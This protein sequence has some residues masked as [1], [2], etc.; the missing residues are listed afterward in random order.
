MDSPYRPRS[1]EMHRSRSRPRSYSPPARS[2][3]SARSRSPSSPRPSSRAPPPR[4]PP[5]VRSVRHNGD[6]KR[7]SRD[8]ARP[9]DNVSPPRRRHEVTLLLC[10]FHSNSHN[11]ST[12][13]V[14]F[15]P[16]KTNDRELWEDIRDTFRADLQKPWRRIFGFMR[17]K[18]I[19]PIAVSAPDP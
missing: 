1:Y 7:K 15:R 6:R 11:W 8:Y 2:M 19:V 16:D 10:V 9:P 4:A 14:R 17:V 3:R 18:N 12:H 5:T 13:P